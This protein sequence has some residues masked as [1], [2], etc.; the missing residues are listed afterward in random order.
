MVKW[1]SRKRTKPSG[2]GHLNHG[3]HCAGS[4]RRR[5]Y[6]ITAAI[7]AAIVIAAG[8]Y[9][10]RSSTVENEFLVLAAQDE[11][12]LSDV[13]REPSC[14]RTHLQLGWTH[15]YNSRFPV[16]GPH[17][18]VPTEPGFY[19]FSQPPIQLVH[20][21]EHGHIVIYYDKLGANARDTLRQWVDLYS[22]AWDGIVVT[23]MPRRGSRIEL[24]AWTRRLGLQKFD[25]AV[26]AAFIDTYWGRG[27]E[28][29]VR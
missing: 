13:R 26:A 25:A 20:A 16:S 3:G 29:P 18:P 1:K 14:G 24:T 22:G 10:W 6:A 21:L 11:A 5:D 17:H 8:K 7:S 27:P 12:A 4:R 19:D 15:S 9:R 28:N 2:S 23:K